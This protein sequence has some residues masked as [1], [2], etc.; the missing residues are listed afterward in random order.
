MTAP[1][2]S[3]ISFLTIVVMGTL[4]VPLLAY[5]AGAMESAGAEDAQ[6]GA[7]MDAPPPV[8]LVALGLLLVAGAVTRRYRK[9]VARTEA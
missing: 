5:T 6:H 4:I 7:L 1:Q 2:R 3:G 8:T 9:N